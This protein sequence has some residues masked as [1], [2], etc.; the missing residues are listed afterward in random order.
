[1]AMEYTDEPCTDAPLIPG[2]TVTA[3]GRV[4]A[5][6]LTEDIDGMPLGVES[7]GSARWEVGT[8]PPDQ[9]DAFLRGEL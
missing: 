1:M 7:V 8:L 5:Y 6:D 2:G 3:S 9:I 4:R